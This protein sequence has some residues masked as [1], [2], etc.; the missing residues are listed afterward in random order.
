METIDNQ[1]TTAKTTEK[2]TR[3]P[4]QWTFKENYDQWD[5]YDLIEIGIANN[6]GRLSMK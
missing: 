5:D 2:P 3:Q 6:G 1:T 4:I